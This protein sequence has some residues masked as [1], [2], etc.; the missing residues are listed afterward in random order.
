MHAEFADIIYYI[1]DG[2][3]SGAKLIDS[4]GTIKV[5]IQGDFCVSRVGSTVTHDLTIDFPAENGEV[6]LCL[7]EDKE[8]YD[9]KACSGCS[10]TGTH[11]EIDLSVV[12]KD[13][14]SGIQ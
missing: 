12:C 11:T 4:T 6:S 10:I 5:P 7:L 9:H 3:G 13:L 2:A 14:A 1:E 8:E